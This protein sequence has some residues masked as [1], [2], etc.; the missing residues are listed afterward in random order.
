MALREPSLVPAE[1]DFFARK[2]NE[3]V[4][5]TGAR[6][7]PCLLDRTDGGQIRLPGVVRRTQQR[8]CSRADDLLHLRIFIELENPP[9]RPAPCCRTSRQKGWLEHS[10]I[11]PGD[12][13]NAASAIVNK[14]CSYCVHVDPEE[15]TV[16]HDIVRPTVSTRRYS[17]LNWCRILI[18]TD[19]DR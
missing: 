16:E 15:Q 3:A 11:A 4:W 14:F 13:T 19:H 6:L 17:P 8:V 1:R 7:G 5:R 12:P 9:A 2:P 18:L 10:T